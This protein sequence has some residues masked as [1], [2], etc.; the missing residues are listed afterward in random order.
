MEGWFINGTCWEVNGES[1]RIRE[2][3]RKVLTTLSFKF[4]D[5]SFGLH[6]HHLAVLLIHVVM[7]GLG[8]PGPLVLKQ[9]Y[10][11]RL[12]FCPAPLLQWCLWPGHQIWRTI[13]QRIL[14]LMSQVSGHR[15]DYRW[16]ISED[17]RCF[18]SV[19][20]VL[21]GFSNHSSSHLR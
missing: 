15:G 9:N 20:T 1:P 19:P 13:S 3:V 5:V 17:G 12:H 18:S 10:S 4:S 11:S 6:C 8:L 2:L 7:Q 21:S 14:E 16:D